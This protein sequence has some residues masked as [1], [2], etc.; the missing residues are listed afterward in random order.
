MSKYKS[1]PPPSMQQSPQWPYNKPRRPRHRLTK[2]DPPFRLNY[3]VYNFTERGRKDLRAKRKEFKRT[4]GEFLEY[5]AEKYAHR[6]RAV[7]IEE[8]EIEAMRQG[9]APVGFT[10][11]HIKPLNTR[12]SDNSFENLVLIPQQP[13]GAR[14][15]K[16]ITDQVQGLKTG[17]TRQVKLPLMRS[18][19][20]PVPKRSVEAVTEARFRLEEE[21]QA[22]KHRRKEIREEKKAAQ[23]ERAAQKREEKR[24]AD[25]EAAFREQAEARAW[26]PKG[27]TIAQLRE[28]AAETGI[29]AD[30]VEPVDVPG[31][32]SMDNHIELHRELIRQVIDQEPFYD[33]LERKRKGKK[34]KGKN[35]DQ[36]GPRTNGRIIFPSG[37]QG[38]IHGMPVVEVEY[39][40]RKKI[41]DIVD[42]EKV[43]RLRYEGLVAKR[44]FLKML[45][46][47]HGAELKRLYDL[48]DCEVQD[49]KDGFSPEGLSVH[50]K[51]PLGGAGD[52]LVAAKA[53]DFD[54]LILIPNDPYHTAIHRHLDP[55]IEDMAMGEKRKVQVAMPE[56]Y[57]FVP[58]TPY[59]R[60]GPPKYETHGR[61]GDNGA[62]RQCPPPG[63]S[64]ANDQPGN[65]QPGNHKR[66]G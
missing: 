44:K 26:P 15:S 14:I 37:P 19:V 50:H 32:H 58:P 42:G 38:D 61:P 3:T 66:L 39:T 1:S 20:F 6:L 13:F 30:V 33:R 53:N 16:Y 46:E 18:P 63:D 27:Y 35:R 22:E 48:T 2:E 43:D 62:D 8:T 40:R 60:S 65:D 24:R 55:Q 54:N 12:D 57:F 64:P 56:G 4:H 45:A 11:R 28:I 52:P 9:V 41:F 36:R 51:R 29:D 5:V 7:G 17:K 49:M 25:E 47:N 21:R 10:V 59:T 34:N 31:D 23:E